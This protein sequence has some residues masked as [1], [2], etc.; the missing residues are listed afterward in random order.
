MKNIQMQGNLNKAVEFLKNLSSEHRY[1]ILCLLVE[2]PRTVG[3]LLEGTGLEQTSISQHLKKLREADIVS[4]TRDHRTITYEIQSPL[5]KKILN[6][7]HD[8]FRNDSF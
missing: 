8:E 2:G 6:L 3:E 1:K 7:L 5:A 4:T